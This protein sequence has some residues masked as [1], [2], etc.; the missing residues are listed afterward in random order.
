[1]IL[2]IRQIHPQDLPHLYCSD[3]RVRAEV[4]AIHHQVPRNNKPTLTSTRLSSTPTKVCPAQ[5][6]TMIRKEVPACPPK[7]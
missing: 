4:R 2:N 3:W 7:S 5:A 1:M 6:A